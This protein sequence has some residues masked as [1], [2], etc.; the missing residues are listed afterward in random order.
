MRRIGRLR[1]ALAVIT[2]ALAIVL[3]D[4]A[5]A[6]PSCE[7]A[8]EASSFRLIPTHP[9]ATEERTATREEMD[10]IA[11]QIGAT[12]EMRA[13]HPLMLIVAQAGT[14]VEVAHRLIARRD[15]DG[16]AYVCDVPSAVV[17]VMGAFKRRVILHKEAAANSCVRKA[18]LDHMARHSQVLDQKIDV[19]IDEHRD[20]LARGVEALTQKA[21]VDEPSASQAFEAGLAALV[22]PVYRQFEVEIERSRLEA[23][24]PEAL[25]QLRAACGGK[26]RE[27]EWEVSGPASK[28]AALQE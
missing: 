13:A 20:E 2:G 9:S 16:D 18:L 4:P 6:A 19:F 27:L 8:W 28:R 7:D 5:T 14:H 10:R 22:G 3:S 23:D 24:T 25:A 21:A 12:A 15:A 1:T 11:A 17:V 26:L